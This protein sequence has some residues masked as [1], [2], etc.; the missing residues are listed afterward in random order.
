ME[1]DGQDYPGNPPKV[2]HQTSMLIMPKITSREA[3]CV[4]KQLNANQRQSPIGRVTSHPP[5]PGTVTAHNC[6]PSKHI[7]GAPFIY[8]SILT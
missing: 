4:Q 2:V 6:C 5:L 1:S 7:N 3:P 8:K